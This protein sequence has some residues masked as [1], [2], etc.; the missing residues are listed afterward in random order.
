MSTNN[1]YISN[2]QYHFASHKLLVTPFK[3][4]RGQ[5]T[6]IIRKFHHINAL[7]AFQLNVI[8]YADNPKISTIYVAREMLGLRLD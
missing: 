8:S 7:V 4:C 1:Y 3:V 5:A 2:G 6:D